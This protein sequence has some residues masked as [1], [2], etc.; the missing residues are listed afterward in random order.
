[1]ADDNLKRIAQELR[2]VEEFGDLPDDELLWL[3]NHVTERTFN[4][5]DCLSKE[6]DQAND[7]IILVDGLLQYRRDS[8]NQDMGLLAV[9]YIP[10]K[11]FVHKLTRHFWKKYFRRKLFL[12]QIYSGYR[13]PDSMKLAQKKGCAVLGFFIISNCIIR[14]TSASPKPCLRFL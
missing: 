11:N 12:L 6:G 1:M 8:D 9:A 7:F 10:P 13:C 2:I 4:P 5:G 14:K 3:A